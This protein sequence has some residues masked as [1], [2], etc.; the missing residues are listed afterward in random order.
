MLIT[1]QRSARRSSVGMARSPTVRTLAASILIAPTHKHGARRSAQNLRRNRSRL[2]RDWRLGGEAVLR[3][4][5]A[6]RLA[7]SRPFGDRA[8]IHRTRA[9]FPAEVS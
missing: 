8:R 7:R 1:D 5:I 9:I 2:G 6:G 3:S 4:W